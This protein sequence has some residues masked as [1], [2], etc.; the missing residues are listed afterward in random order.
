MS[1]VVL[2]K[3]LIETF[4]LISEASVVLLYFVKLVIQ[5]PLVRSLS[6]RIEVTFTFLQAF[7][8]LLTNKFLFL[9]KFFNSLTYAALLADQIFKG[10]LL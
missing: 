6:Q 10:F 8:N 1:I 2:L 7:N 3:S 4:E 9:L 5:L